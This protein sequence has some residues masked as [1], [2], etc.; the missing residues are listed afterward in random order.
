MATVKGKDL[1]LFRKEGQA[2]K[3]YAASKECSIKISMDT[4]D[5]SSK[6]S[7]IWKDV[8]PGKL[9]W[10]LSTNGLFVS[11]EF[12][13]LF[14]LMTA[15]EPID[16]AF[17]VPDNTGNEMPEGGWSL[18][19]GHYE[20]KAYITS[21]DGSGPEEGDGTYSLELQGSGKLNQVDKSAS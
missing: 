14:A 13:K 17:D 20:G 19:K 16:C 6:D 15:R 18:A 3:A 1:M 21:L 5:S 12:D 7:G 4:S 2:Y 8:V 9:G 10:S 11:A